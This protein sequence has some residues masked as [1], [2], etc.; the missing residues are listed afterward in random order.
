M[1]K[2][3]RTYTP[4]QLEHYYLKLNYTREHIAN[5]FHVSVNIVDDDIHKYG[6]F[7]SKE[8][9][10]LSQG[11]FKNID[12]N[13][14]YNYYIIQNHTTEETADYFNVNERTVRRRLRKFGIIKNIEAQKEASIRKQIEKYGDIFTKSDY[15]KKYIVEDM[16]EKIRQ[17]CQTKY[18]VDS[19]FQTK[20]SQHDRGCKYIY[21]NERFDSSWELAFWI[22][23]EDFQLDVKH[24]PCDLVYLVNNREH[25]YF[26][27]FLYNGQLIDIKG[28]HLINDS[29]N[30]AAVY[31]TAKYKDVAKQ[32]CMNNN[33]VI[34][35]KYEDIKPFLKYVQEKYGKDYLK[36]FKKLN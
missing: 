32:Q 8:L 22:Y 2:I 16:V 15:Y 30:L 18:G 26:P 3:E 5:M 14:L 27:D 29:G 21:K 35:W 12:Y 1:K 34:I 13:E 24:E 4:E 25:H 7:K 10:L 19:Y 23:A 6:L 36:S 33:N 9:C 20:Q 31:Q 11:Q 17:T 28:D